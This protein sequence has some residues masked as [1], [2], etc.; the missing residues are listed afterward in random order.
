MKT[1]DK[2][3]KNVARFVSKNPTITISLLYLFIIFMLILWN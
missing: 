2:F 3:E 1:L